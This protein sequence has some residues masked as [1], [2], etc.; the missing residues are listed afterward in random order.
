MLKKRVNL[1]TA[2]VTESEYR[3]VYYRR[4]QYAVRSRMEMEVLGH[5][6]LSRMAL[7]AMALVHDEAHRVQEVVLRFGRST[8]VL[9]TVRLHLSDVLRR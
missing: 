7:T 8:V 1:A 6:E 2:V 5:H 3:Y 4:L 9:R